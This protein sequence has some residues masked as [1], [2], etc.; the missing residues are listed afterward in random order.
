MS[1]TLRS[2]PLQATK[3]LRTARLLQGLC[4]VGGVRDASRGPLRHDSGWSDMTR[5]LTTG[6]SLLPTL[7]YPGGTDPPQQPAAEPT[8]RSFVID[9]DQHPTS[10]V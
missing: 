9:I 5:F 8:G 3:E 1:P 4:R 10:I 2:V 6:R 7:Q